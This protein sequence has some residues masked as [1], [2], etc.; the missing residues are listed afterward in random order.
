MEKIVLAPSLLS[1]DFSNLE[2]ALNTIEKNNGGAVHIDVM[3]GRFVPQITY[4]QP[5]VKSLRA[6]TQLPFDVH[7][8]VEHPECQIESFALS[9]ADWITFHFENTVHVHRIVQ[10]IHSLGKKAGIAIC[11]ATP[12]DF[13]SEILPEIDIVLVMTV[14]PGFGGQ[15]LIPSCVKKIAALKEIREKFGYGYKISVDGGVNAETAAMVVN[16]GADIVVSG[17]AFFS[18]ALKWPV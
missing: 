11:P 3:D 5:V 8:M 7:L 16:A 6:L 15:K 12:V 1:A 18:G 14:N 13:I 10:Q 4:G 9:G 17:S 2:N